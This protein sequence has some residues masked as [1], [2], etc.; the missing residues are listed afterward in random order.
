MNQVVFSWNQL[1]GIDLSL[2]KRAVYYGDGFFETMRWYLGRPLFW[3]HHKQRIEKTAS[4]LSLPLPYSVDML[5]D[6]LKKHLLSNVPHQR[7]R[8]SF[9]RVGEGYYIPTQNKLLIIVECSPLP[10]TGY[11]WQENTYKVGLSSIVKLRHPLSGLKLLSAANYVMAGIEAQ[12]KNWDEAILLNEAGNIC[13]AVSH[14]VFFIK[15]N[16]VITPP[17]EEGCLAGIMRTHII[18]LCKKNQIPVNERS[19]PC[20]E[21]HDAEEIF[22]TNVISGIRSVHILNQKKLKNDLTK[23]IF[24]K[25]RESFS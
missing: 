13:E 8:I 5:L 11:L 25:L 6:E 24:Q 4:I 3:Q 7:L 19:I 12:Q 1:E 15:Q 9:V 18:Q 23:T 21:L 10:E 20:N 16:T 17:L 2:L 14:N 22:L